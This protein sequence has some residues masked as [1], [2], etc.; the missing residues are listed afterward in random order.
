MEIQI[1]YKDEN[2]VA[3]NKPAGI[4]VHKTA[5]AFGK[6]TRKEGET[7]A[8]WAIR[9]FPEIKSVGDIHTSG[10]S[11]IERSG[12]VH[13]LD[14][15]TSGVIIIARNQ[16]SFLDL[17]R[18]FQNHEVRKTYLALVYGDVTKKGVIDKP[19]GLKPGTI[20]RSVTA[21]KMKMIKRAVTEYAPEKHFGI[22]TLLNVWPKTGRTHQIRVH[23]S[24]IGHPIVGDI[25]YGSKKQVIEARRQFLHAE[26]I[27]FTTLSGKRMKIEAELPEDLKSILITL[28]NLK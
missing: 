4:L 6:N 14:R 19:I 1:I 22:A 8:D 11:F 26:S 23:L 13:R 9:R 25:L 12:I 17:K 15:E 5:A 28:E 7:V 16:G 10:G 21:K 20:K 3:V 27:E 2:I 18:Q 24:S